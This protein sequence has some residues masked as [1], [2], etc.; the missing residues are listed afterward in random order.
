MINYK[1]FDI[2]IT[3]SREFNENGSKFRNLNGLVFKA[4]CKFGTSFANNLENALKGAYKLIDRIF[5]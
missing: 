1:G 3:E 4:E 2:K 5:N